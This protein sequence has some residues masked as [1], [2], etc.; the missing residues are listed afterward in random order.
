MQLIEYRKKCKFNLE[1]S[2]SYQVTFGTRSLRIQGPKVCNYLLYHIKV[3][4]NL[5]MF[6]NS[7]KI[8]QRKFISQIKTI[9]TSLSFGMERPAV[10][11]FAQFI[12]R[13]LTHRMTDLVYVTDVNDI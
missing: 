5:E 11:T 13:N 1:I 8:L 2:N 10:A 6:P 4:E 12:M 9:K 3:A 7:C